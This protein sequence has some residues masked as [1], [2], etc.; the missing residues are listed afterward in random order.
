MAGHHRSTCVKLHLM[1]NLSS[2]ELE[3]ILDPTERTRLF[4]HPDGHIQI[5]MK[6]I[7]MK[8]KKPLRLKFEPFSIFWLPQDHTIITIQQK[9]SDLITYR[10]KKRLAVNTSKIRMNGSA[11]FMYSLLDRIVDEAFR[12]SKAFKNELKI[13]EDDIRGAGGHSHMQQHIRDIYRIK[14]ELSRLRSHLRPING[15]IARL[16]EML[17][18]DI[19]DKAIIGTGVEGEYAITTTELTILLHDVLDHIDSS[20]KGIDNDIDWCASIEA[21]V[22]QFIDNT[23]SQALFLLALVSF[24][25]I[26]LQF[27]TGV[28]GMNFSNMPELN[29][30]YGYTIF[31][32]CIL[33]ITSSLIF[34]LKHKGCFRILAQIAVT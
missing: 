4:K 33:L 24:I 1:Y 3:D 15:V 34:F 12:A 32:V 23:Q 8:K 29:K 9:H 5:V 27:V 7:R 19:I 21:M 26:P 2:L 6:L 20:I 14:K 18:K 22:K 17:E 25:F 13:L 11:Y 16:V 28:Y 31:W 10:L 30:R